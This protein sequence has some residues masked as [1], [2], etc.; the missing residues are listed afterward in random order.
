MNTSVA[1]CVARGGPSC[2]IIGPR[3]GPQIARM[4][5]EWENLGEYDE[6]WRR[7]LEQ[8]LESAQP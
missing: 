3:Y 1:T 2:L 4:Q 7:A 8:G 6:E 5:R